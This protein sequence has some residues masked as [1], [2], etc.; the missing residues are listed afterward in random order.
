M[1]DEDYLIG[2]GKIVGNLHAIEH[3]LRIFLCRALGEQLTYPTAAD[4]DVPLTSLTDYRSLSA[5]IAA[6]NAR[7]GAAEQQFAADTDIVDIRDALAHGRTIADAPAFPI[8]LY[9]FGRPVGARV[10]IERVDVLDESWL[11]HNRAHVRAQIDKVV[12]CAQGRGYKIG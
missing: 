8:T 10:P 9:K 2:I 4:K 5:I 1:K 7:L 11:D 12:A 3:L 6:Y